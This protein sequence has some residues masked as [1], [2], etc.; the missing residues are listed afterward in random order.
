MRY[1]PPLNRSLILSDNSAVLKFCEINKYYCS[2]S[3]N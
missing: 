1:I 2:A 3:Y